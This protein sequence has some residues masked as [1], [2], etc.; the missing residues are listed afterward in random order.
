MK[1][2]DILVPVD[3]SANSL[4]AI[5]FALS[6]VD[7]NGEICLLHVIDS[8][9][10]SQ[11]AD[12]GFSDAAAATE[13]LRKNAESRFSETIANMPPDGPRIESMIVVGKPF[14]EILRVATDLD[15][16]FIVIGTHGIRGETLEDLL[17]GSTAEKVLR[18]SAIPVICVPDGVA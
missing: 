12:E 11:L 16:Q 4:R 15:F 13:K 18:G 5:D 1:I 7:P 2:D 3:F 10:V 8:E 6:A 14:A 17:F 9:F